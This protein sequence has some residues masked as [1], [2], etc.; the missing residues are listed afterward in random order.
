MGGGWGHLARI[1]PIARELSKRHRVV[2]AARQFSNANFGKAELMALPDN[3]RIA[4]PSIA[5]SFPEILAEAGWDDPSSLMQQCD[6]RREFCAQIK[7]DVLVM[8]Y[9]PTALLA[10]QG[11]PMRRVL[12]S[13]GFTS[14]P[15]IS[16]LP[17]L[18]PMPSPNA[19]E[20]S[21]AIELKV[22]HAANTCLQS[23]P[24][25][26]LASLFTRVDENIFATWPEL[27]HY[28]KRAS[29]NYH[30]VW[31][32]IGGT[33]VNWPIVDGPRVLLYLKMFPALPALLQML[34]HAKLPTLATITGASTEF[35]Q[36]ENSES[37]HVS[38]EPLDLVRAAGECDLAILNAG[39]GAT[40]MVLRAGA[41]ILQIPLVLE[42][43]LIAKRS[44]EIGAA[45]MASS[46]SAEQ[47][48]NAFQRLLTDRRFTDAAEKFSHRYRD[49]DPASAV[50]GIAERI[51]SLA[52]FP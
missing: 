11:L 8:D 7:P 36:R 49:F 9:A 44:I 12:L 37:I 3:Q 34:R 22:L 26:R 42:Q 15:D 30:G 6:R 14:P 27:D 39:H 4:A 18:N 1:A 16:P 35:I 45:Q 40:A 32:D 21:A 29:A 31:G 25:P 28:G 38:S 48:A 47:I 5:E 50:Q 17:V 20:K 2:V 10:S 41:P 23:S 51:D 24:L 52:G 33:A 46:D 13:S 43:F 19:V